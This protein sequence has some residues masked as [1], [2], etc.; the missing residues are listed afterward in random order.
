[1]KERDAARRTWAVSRSVADRQAY[2]QLRNKAKLVLTRARRSHLTEQLQG[3]AMRFW[4][5]LRQFGADLSARSTSCATSPP[6]ETRLSADQLN[7]HFAAV[8]ARVAAE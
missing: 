5:R 3:D 8:G 6:D 7:Q 1:M 4:T 2:R